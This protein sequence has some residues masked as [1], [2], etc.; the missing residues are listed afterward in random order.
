MYTHILYNQ[1]LWKRIIDDIILIWHHGKDSLLEFIDHSNIV[2]L[3][4]KFTSDISH[5]EIYFLDLTIYIRDYKL[6]TRLYT[7]TTDRH[8]YLNYSSEHCMSLKGSISYSQFLRLKRIHSEPECLFEA[9]I[10]MYIFF[11]WREYPHEFVLRAWMKPNR[12]TREQLLTPVEINQ[13]K[14]IPL[15]F[16][17]IYSRAY[18]NFKKLF[19]N[20]GLT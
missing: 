11:V 8:F 15:M 17:M 6:Y 3:T 4:I 13:D 19:S 5:T 10:H 7:K 20:T 2:H 14:D 1:K 16:I 12:P 18:P 9:Q